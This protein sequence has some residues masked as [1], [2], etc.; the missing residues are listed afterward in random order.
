LDRIFKGENG[1]QKTKIATHFPFHSLI[2]ETKWISRKAKALKSEFEDIIQTFSDDY[3]DFHEIT[4][5]QG[6][7]MIR[8]DKYL[9]DRLQKVSRNRI[10]GAI[11]VGAVRVNQL[12]VK[13]NYKVRPGD[14]IDMVI[15][16]PPGEGVR[17][18]P[19]DIPLNVVYE[20]E[21]VLVIDKPAGMVV[22]PGVGHRK[23]T[24][25]N[26]LAYHFADRS[27]PVMEGNLH[28]RIGLVHRIDR[29]TSGLLVVAKTDFAMNH[30][31]KQ[32]YYHTIERRYVAL[33]WG[34]PEPAEGSIEGNIG[35]HPRFPTL[36]HCFSDGSDGKWALT[37]Y[38]IIEPLYY[39]S[40]VECMLETGRTHQIRVHMKHIG[41][42]LFGDDKYGGGEILKGTV[43]SKYKQFVH[44]CFDMLPRHALH[45]RTLGFEHPVTRKWMQFA[46]PLPADFEKCIQAWRDYVLERKSKNNSG[47]NET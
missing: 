30:L 3:Y 22:H 35:R 28:D 34:E 39:V 12:E 5:D 13:P 31:A 18:V 27:L 33:V 2:L 44:A 37:H 24:L 8:I 16:R 10:Q 46:S 43:Y 14:K 19:Q 20:D 32:F 47:D 29:N 25:V 21:A 23:D 38:R 9:C 40:V 41:H 26:A 17:L 36:R 45:A 42:P 4:V 15:P 6:Q 11:K 1:F 7:G